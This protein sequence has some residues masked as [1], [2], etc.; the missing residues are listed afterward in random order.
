MDRRDTLKTLLISGLAG[1]GGLTFVGCETEKKETS[2]KA[3]S[4]AKGYGR[5]PSEQAFDDKLRASP[6]V[7][8]KGELATMAILCD[9]ILP[10]TATAGAATDAAVVEF[11]DFI[12]KDIPNHQ[13]PLKGGLMWLERES[14]VRFNLSFAE[15]GKDNQIAIVEAIAW[16]ERA[17]PE[18]QPGVAFFNRMRNLVLTGY[19]T[20]KMGITDLGYKGNVPNVWDGVPEDV[21]AQH[22]VTYDPDWTAKCVDQSKRMVQ[23]EWDEQ[24]NLLT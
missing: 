16:P 18:M 23:A 13:L 5:T 9:I 22:G 6:S 10:A 1:A 19:Y 21:L 7:F 4:P 24:G 8:T 15:L 14:L 2:L 3:A 11:I 12:V 20:S 17:T